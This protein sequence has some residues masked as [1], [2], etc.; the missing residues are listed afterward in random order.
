MQKIAQ[1]LKNY[2]DGEYF[3]FIHSCYVSPKDKN[4]VYTTSKYGDFEFCS[5]IL[6]DNIF[7]CQFHPEKSGKKGIQILSETFNQK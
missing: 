1:P 5:S 2:N 7:A 6:K 3:Y 4:N